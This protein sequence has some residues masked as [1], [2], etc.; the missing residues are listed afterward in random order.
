MVTLL[1]KE[2]KLV[3][4]EGNQVKGKL[5]KA[6][7]FADMEAE[8]CWPLSKHVDYMKDNNLTEMNVFLAVPMKVS[9]FFWCKHFGE[10]GEKGNCGQ[11]CLA[12]EP[13]NGESGICRHHGHFHEPVMNPYKLI[14]E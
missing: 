12:Y 3:S 6:M 5:L 10:M 11:E 9:G 4:P 8:K 7:Y 1:L 13:R 2:M 14:I